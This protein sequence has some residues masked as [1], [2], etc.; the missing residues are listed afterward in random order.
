M[1]HSSVVISSVSS[2]GKK[3]PH[4][5]VLGEMDGNTDIIADCWVMDI[6][7]KCWKQVNDYT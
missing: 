1:L 7:E 4:L 2:D 5:V 6:E 3:R